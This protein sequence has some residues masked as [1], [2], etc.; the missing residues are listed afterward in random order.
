MCCQVWINGDF[1]TAEQ[2][3]DIVEIAVVIDHEA[4]ELLDISLANDIL[5]NIDERSY[6]ERID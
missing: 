1:L 6:H 3:P 5:S 4:F 2:D